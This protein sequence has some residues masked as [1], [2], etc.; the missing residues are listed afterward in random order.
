MTESLGQRIKRLREFKGLSQ[1]DLAQMIDKHTNSIVNYER[2][3][4]KPT[5]DAL[6]KILEKFQDV[7]SDWLLLGRGEMIGSKSGGSIIDQR[8]ENHEKR[9][10]E[11]ERQ[12]LQQTKNKL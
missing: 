5:F 12:I 9:L 8:L 4:V 1:P 6:K 7:N 2:D 10:K 11:L 3:Q